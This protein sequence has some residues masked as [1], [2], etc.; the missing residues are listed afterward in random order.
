MQPDFGELGNAM[1]LGHAAHLMS[2]GEYDQAIALLEFTMQS[3]RGAFLGQVAFRLGIAYIHASGY[4][5]TRKIINALRVASEV[6]VDRYHQAAAADVLGVT[7]MSQGDRGTA[8]RFFRQAADSTVTDVAGRA[9]MNLAKVHSE[10]ATDHAD[11]I[12]RLLRQVVASGVAIKPAH[13]ALKLANLLMHHGLHGAA[14]EAFRVATATTDADVVR[15]AHDSLHLMQ[16]MG[17][18]PT[19]E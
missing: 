1:V 17:L 15:G 12:T 19:S 9:A 8:I 14:A 7:Y 10:Q 11:E 18:I 6:T 2:Q 13:D 16:V 4:R 3:A 5:H